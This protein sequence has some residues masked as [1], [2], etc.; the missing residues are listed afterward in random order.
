MRNRFITFPLDREKQNERTRGFARIA[1]F[2]MLQGAIDYTHFAMRAQHVNLVI[3]MNKKGFHSLNV[4]LV[5]DHTQCIMGVNTRYPESSHN[6]FTMRQSNMP[7]IF[8]P[9]RQ[10]KGWLLGDQ[11]YPL[12]RWLTIPV[13]NTRTRA[14]WAYN[15]S[16]AAMCN[17]IDRTI[18]V[19]KQCFRCLDRCVGTL[20]YSAERVSRFIVVCCTLHDLVIMREQSLPPIIQ[21]DPEPEEEEAEAEGEEEAEDER[22]EMEGEVEE[23]KEHWPNLPGLCVLT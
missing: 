13:R 6:V 1:G 17:V 11:G 12:M 7:A 8:E 22:E 18:G 23:D 9:A 20:Q 2:P 4:Q 16:H 21:H 19:L 5:Y 15:E 10:V 14:E 3:Y